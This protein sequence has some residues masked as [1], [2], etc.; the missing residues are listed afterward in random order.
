MDDKLTDADLLALWRAGDGDAGGKLMDRNFPR[1][2]KFFARKT[3]DYDLIKELTQRTFERCIEKVH[4]FEGRSS[5]SSFIYGIARNIL[6][7]HFRERQRAER[8]VPIEDIPIVD[9][10]PTPF[11]IVEQRSERKLIIHALRRLPL[12]MQIVAELYFFEKLSGREVA[13]VLE[14]SEGTVRGR[15]RACRD[16]L[17]GIIHDLAESPE[18]LESTLMT[19]SSWAQRVREQI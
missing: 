18:Q 16:Q 7:E 10:D 8:D 1:I 13:E 4:A 19:L 6:L 12:K 2:K 17:Q 14:L 9:L 3:A 11:S 15:I 5:F